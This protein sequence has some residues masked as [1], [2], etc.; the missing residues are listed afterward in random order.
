MN[1]ELSDF[2]VCIY[3][4]MRR[5]QLQPHNDDLCKFE[6]KPVCICAYF[7]YNFIFLFQMS[8]FV[9]TTYFN[10]SNE[11][12]FK[13]IDFSFSLLY[14]ERILLLKNKNVEKKTCQKTE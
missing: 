5:M 7:Y 6:M 13:K 1:F 3:V 12:V 10:F 8:F 4:C 11:K 9:L 14:R 2:S